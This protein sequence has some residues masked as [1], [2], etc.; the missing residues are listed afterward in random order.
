MMTPKTLED[1]KVLIA[2]HNVDL[3]ALTK[4]ANWQVRDAS[5]NVIEDCYRQRDI[6]ILIEFIHSQSIEIP[7]INAMLLPKNQN[8]EQVT[9]F[10][11]YQFHGAIKAVGDIIGHYAHSLPEGIA[12]NINRDLMEISLSF[13]TPEQI[14]D[15]KQRLTEKDSFASKRNGAAGLQEA[16]ASI[17][18]QRERLDTALTKIHSILEPR[19]RRNNE[20]I[21]KE[22][23]ASEL[24]N[25]QRDV[26]HMLCKSLSHVPTSALRAMAQEFIGDKEENFTA[27]ELIVILAELQSGI[28][29]P[30][31]Y[32]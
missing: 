5:G 19:E 11:L 12:E 25:Q 23:V 30:K 16:I 7:R 27:D 32:Q 10:K 13:L 1:L 14:Q 6:N 8:L 24:K 22:R 3:K 15:I 9:S 29:T 2:E 26:Y 31:D 28:G 17:A 18:V 20:E 21:I 4:C